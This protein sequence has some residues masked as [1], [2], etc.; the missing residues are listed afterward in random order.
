MA[1]QCSW[2][3]ICEHGLLST[4]ALLDLF[5]IAGK[6]RRPIEAAHRP[7]SVQIAHPVHG[8]AV[9]RDQ[10]PMS[11]KK[12]ASCLT[13]E[14][15]PESWYRGLNRRVF[16][17]ATRERLQCMV[18]ARAYRSDPQIV[19]TIA[20]RLLVD[21]YGDQVEVATINTGSTAYQAQSRG[22]GTF[23]PLADFDYGKS[24]RKR[25]RRK[26]IA[27]VVVNHAVPGV[28]DLVVLVER[29]IGGRPSSVIWQ[30]RAG[31]AP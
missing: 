4:S 11:D 3:S 28:T 1:H 30:A 19:L 20:T 13:H 21:R 24:R 8:R 12:L 23:V 31:K 16:F 27:E 26:A 25:G 7:D 14:M 5:E 6:E 29:W 10:K 22:P 9:I 2:P 18:D 17:W 15:T